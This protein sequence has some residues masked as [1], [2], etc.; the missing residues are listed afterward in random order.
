MLYTPIFR[1][2]YLQEVL[3]NFLTGENVI[4]LTKKDL[5]LLLPIS[6]SSLV[7]CLLVISIYWVQPKIEAQLV[8]DVKLALATHRIEATVSFSGR[9]GILTGEVASQK[10]SDNAYKLSLAVFGTRVI[11]NNL[12]VKV[13]QNNNVKIVVEQNTHLIM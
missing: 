13:K 11:K 6:I 8:S 12:T 10:I 4:Q 7:I 1:L 9:D 3:N 2:N 5:F